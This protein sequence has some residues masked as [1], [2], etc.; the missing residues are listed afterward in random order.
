MLGSDAR[1]ARDSVVLPAPE[2]DDMMRRMP[3]LGMWTRDS[4]LFNVLNLLAEL[5]DHGFELEADCGQAAVRR[6][7]TQRVGFPVELLCEEI[8]LAADR[9]GGLEEFPRRLDMGE[10]PIDFFLDIRTRG[11]KNGLLVEAI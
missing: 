9:F 4:V 8:E 3:R 11:E 6:L 10:E 2:G 5:V 7:R 1:R